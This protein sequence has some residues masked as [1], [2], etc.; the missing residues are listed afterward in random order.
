MFRTIWKAISCALHYLWVLRVP[1][2]SAALL[3][4]LPTLGFRPTLRPYVA[5]IFDL[6]SKWALTLVVPLALFNAW[7]IVIVAGLILTYG[8]VRFHLPP[9]HLSLPP[10]RTWVW[11]VS[12]LPFAA[13][14]IIRTITFSSVLADLA[15]VL[16]F[17]CGIGLTAALVLPANLVNR[18]SKRSDQRP[19]YAALLTRVNRHPFLSAGFLG[20]VNG[21]LALLPGHGRAFGFA[22]ASIVLYVATGFFTRN[23]DRR[24]LASMLEYVLLLVLMLT[25]LAAFLAFV[26]DRTRV[27]LVALLAV[28]LLVVT[29]VLDY[30]TPTDNEYRTAAFSATAPKLGELPTLFDGT[31]TPI[32]VA[33]SGGGIQAAAWTARVLTAL[34]E[35][36]GFRPNLRLVSAVSGGS[37]GTMNVLASWP[38]CGPAPATAAQRFDPNEASRASSLHA[39][40]WGLVFKDLPRAVVPFFSNPFVD[41]GSVLEDAWKRE[42]RLRRE[43]PDPAPLLASWRAGVSEHRC[44]GVVFN[45]MAA[46]TGE[47]MLF[48]TVALPGTL[49]PYSFYSHYPDRDVP[50]T[51]A[52]RL[53]AAFPYVSPAARADADDTKKRYLHLVDGGYFDNYGVTA[54]AAIA[55]VALKEP[56]GD[57]IGHLLVIEICDAK[58]C[59][60][61]DPRPVP[62]DGGPRRAWP[63][64]L[65]APPAAL[66][67]MRGS[68]QRATNR[69]AIRLL[70]EAWQERDTCIETVHAPFGTD[71]A[72]LSWHLTHDDQAA[73]D[74]KWKTDAAPVLNAVAEYVTGNPATPEGAKCIAAVRQA[75]S[76][77]NLHRRSDTI[78]R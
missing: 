6:L 66:L 9:T 4:A 69:T 49:A 42:E 12:G 71:D 44:P 30:I 1:V 52:V 77:P 65:T 43:L 75:R 74:A 56:A 28:W 37:V 48:S 61:K 39:V 57:D 29:Y 15:W 46:E 72:P 33:V 19:W 31:A 27:P 34:G 3:V 70:K 55:T 62:S 10:Q 8:G 22:F 53:S 76:L 14:I 51:T 50:M 41:R 20:Q 17:A 24:V 26:F 13:P 38:D 21:R 73:I 67:T 47:P 54:L 35:I 63:Y 5:G 32:V 36:E 60:G 25:W 7:T 11:V 58:E 40:G 2:L 16:P 45:S 59:S 18:F 78:S 64:Q 68:A 23:L